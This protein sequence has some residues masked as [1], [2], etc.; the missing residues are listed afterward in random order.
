MRLGTPIPN[1]TADTTTGKIKFYEWAGTSWV[2]L[3]SHPADFTPVCTTELGHIA[4]KAQEFFRR[5]VMLLGHSS[6][7]V[8]RHRAWIEDIRSQYNITGQ[9]PYP[10]IGDESRII[11]EQ[12]DMTDMR[13]PE[14]RGVRVVYIIGPDKTLRLSMLYPESTGRNVDEVLRV[15]DS[16]QLANTTPVVTPVDWRMG[17]DVLLQP[18][19]LPIDEA[20]LFPRGVR[21]INLPS[22]L[23][24]VRYTSDYPMPHECWE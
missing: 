12:L 21:R 6:D 8:A 22:G 18:D 16:L 19:V 14:S 10:V 15:I 9:F 20:R 23:A 24:Y 2:M 7:S 13:D 3:F 4:G 11:A 1:F 5:G 17:E